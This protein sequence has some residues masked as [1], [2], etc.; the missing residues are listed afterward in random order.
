MG[1]SVVNY[2]ISAQVNIFNC[3]GIGLS[4]SLTHKMVDGQSYFAFMKAW[5][6][7]A[8]GSSET[9]ISPSFITSDVFPR[10]PS[11]DCWFPIQSVPTKLIATKRFMFDSM[12]LASLK[13]QPVAGNN[14]NT[15]APTRTEAA[16]ALIW[17]AAA[18]AALTVKPSSSQ[19]E[20]P[21][22]LL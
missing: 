2:V 10:N 5:A 18:K 6:A 1:S 20:S 16:T 8:R 12:A 3:G 11:L 22:A 7:V 17:K 13:N 14:N 9:I 19:D 15:R 4:M 21:H